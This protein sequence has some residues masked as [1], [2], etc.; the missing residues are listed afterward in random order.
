MSEEVKDT[1]QQPENSTPEASGGQGSEKVFTQ[2]EVNRIVSDRLAREREKQT[3]PPKESEREQA[4]KAR[5][6]RLDCRDYLDSKKYPT[7]LMDVLDASDVDQFKATVEKLAKAFPGV[8][9]QVEQLKGAR[10]APYGAGTGNASMMGNS[11]AAAFKP[12]KF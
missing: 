7:A 12:P 1:Q 5:E 4:L 9:A 6:A 3:P 8:F 2:E 11:I 10:P